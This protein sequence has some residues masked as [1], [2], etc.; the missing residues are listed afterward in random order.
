[1]ETVRSNELRAFF[2]YVVSVLEKFDISYMVVGGFAVI[3]YGAPRLTID[4]DIV[5]DMQLQHVQTFVGAFPVPTYYASEEGIR[6]SLLRRYPF[7]VIEPSTGAKVDLVPLPSDLFSRFAFQRRQ[8]M[9]YDEAGHAA[10]FITAEDIILAKLLAYRETNSDKHLQDA[11]GVLLMQ[12]DE[13][14]WNRIQRAANGANVA[15]LLEPLVEAVRQE[16]E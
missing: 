16:L 14:N 10:M 7:N 12:W 15:E 13:L 11:R 9:V 1:M 2:T 6:D 5:V 4:V 3:F 8:R